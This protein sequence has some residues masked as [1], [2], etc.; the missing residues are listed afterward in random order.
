[1]GSPVE[2]K[3]IIVR[4][5]ENFNQGDIEACAA[6]FSEDTVNHGRPVGKNGIRVVLGDI[7]ATFP[8]FHQEIREMVCEGDWVV[9]RVTASGTHKGVNAIPHHNIPP[10]TEP[11]GRRFEAQII[12]M[13]RV[14][15]GKIVEHWAGRDDVAIL[16]QLG[17]LT[18]GAPS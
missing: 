17:I 13:Q 10:G 1:M 5:I 14:V 18:V 11:T 12:H 3:R 2:N 15:D 16:T 9:S 4:Q 8:D 7:L 6:D